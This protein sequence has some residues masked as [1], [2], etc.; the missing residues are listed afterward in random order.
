[1]KQILKLFVVLFFIYLLLYNSYEIVETIKFSFDICI[2]NLFP[3]LIPFMLLS[4]ILINYNFIESLNE[5]LT[6]ITKLLKINKNCS[7][8]IIMSILSGTPS[9]SVYIKELLENN[10][11][12]IE[13][14]KKCLNFCHFTNPIFILTVIGYSFLN[15]KKLGLIILI[16]HY[17]SSFIIGLFNKKAN[18]IN[19]NTLTKTKSNENFIQVLKKSINNTTSNLLLIMGIITTFSIIICLINNIFSINDNYKFIYGFLEVTNGLKYVAISK[20]NIKIKTILS[21]ILISFGGLCIHA[22]I[23]CILENKKIKYLPYFF[24]RL[25]HALLSAISTFILLNI[26][27]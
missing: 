19:L 18:Q 16:S 8:I 17:F 2:N 7:F 20:F 27:L 13:D 23:F 22:Q 26:T 14:A 25:F 5:L 15:N 11:I 24:S 9:N 6:P 10:L 3:S 1:M 4:N 21:S 12:T